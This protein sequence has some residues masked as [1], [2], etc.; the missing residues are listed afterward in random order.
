MPSSSPCVLLILVQARD[1]LAA[2]RTS[3][4]DLTHRFNELEEM[5]NEIQEI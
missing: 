2:L 5:Y 4:E 1:E 3:H